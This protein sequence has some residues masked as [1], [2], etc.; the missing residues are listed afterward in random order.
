MRRALESL[1]VAQLN[2]S[3]QRFEL[4]LA[5]CQ[6]AGDD[7]R[8]A[9]GTAFSMSGSGPLQLAQRQERRDIDGLLHI[10]V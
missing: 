5:L 4:E 6:E 10:T 1:R 9:V 7:A 2:R 3:A 8:Y